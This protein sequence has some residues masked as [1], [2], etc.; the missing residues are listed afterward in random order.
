M[1]TLL[2][3]AKALQKELTEERRYLHAHAEVGFALEKTREYIQMKLKEFGYTPEKCGKGILVR[4]GKGKRKI[5]LRADMDGLPVPEET[6]LDFACKYGNMHA[7]GHDI[8]A[9]ALLTTAKLLK[10]REKELKGEVRLYF[11]P[12]EEILQ[13]AKNGIENGVVDGVEFAVML[14]VLTGVEMPTGRAIVSSQG[15]SAPCADY[16]KIEVK[17]K[18]C[19]GSSP[20]EGIDALTVSARILLA[21]QELSAREISPF[22]KAVLTVGCLRAGETGNV[23]CDSAEMQGTLRCFEEETREHIKKRLTEISQGIAKSFYAKAKIFFQGGCPSLYN[24]GKASEFALKT[25]KELL[26][27]ECVFASSDLP[28]GKSV[29][30]SEDFAY[31]S[32]EVP[33]IMIAVTA[34][35]KK[36][37]YEY[38]LHHPKAKF[39]EEVLPIACALYTGLALSWFL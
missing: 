12:A 16:F 14:H 17:G 6:G 4:I 28:T 36:K 5:L 23:I 11:Q 3:E 30:G 8:H 18:G 26:G 39:D 21:L 7:C 29:N 35:E 24:D 13:G 22:E 37:G 10:K 25:A 38:P 32:R 34:G 1:K 33:S 9:T 2:K 20:W 15:V 27:E 19:H 31:I